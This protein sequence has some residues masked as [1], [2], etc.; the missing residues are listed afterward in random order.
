MPP[1]A[2]QAVNVIKEKIKRVLQ[3]KK[4][5][6]TNMIT[7]IATLAIDSMLKLAKV[8]VQLGGQSSTNNVYYSQ[9]KSRLPA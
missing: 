4:N 8:H 1:T 5:T 9:R 3:K 7:C 6:T 2:A